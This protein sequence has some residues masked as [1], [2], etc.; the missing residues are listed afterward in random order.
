F[1]GVF[2]NQPLEHILAVLKRVPLDVVQLHGDECL[3]MA[4]SIPAP[5]FKA[6]HMDDTF[7]GYAQVSTMACHQVALLDAKVAGGSGAQGGQGVA[8]NWALAEPVTRTGQPFILA[9]GLRSDNV[10]QAI[11]QTRPWMVDVSSGVE[12]DGVKDPDKVRAF[13]AAVKASP[14]RQ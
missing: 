12:T 10:A 9:G 5:V 3:S 11:Q 7:N 6:F 4:H 1:V 8:F 14:Q 2:R 13:I